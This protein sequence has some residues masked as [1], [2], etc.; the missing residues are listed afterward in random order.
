MAMVARHASTSSPAVSL[1]S[2]AAMRLMSSRDSCPSASVN[3][4]KVISR[5]LDTKG[6]RVGG[7]PGSPAGFLAPETWRRRLA[8]GL[9]ANQAVEN[10]GFGHQDGVES[11][12]PE[13]PDQHDDAPHD[14]PDS[15]PLEP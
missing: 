4:V 2:D 11:E 5:I 6:H 10:V 3:S 14:H 12:F 8:S 1:V 7:F 15:A 13:D 9:A